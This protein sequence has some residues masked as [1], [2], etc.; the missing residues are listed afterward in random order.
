VLQQHR[1]AILQST[2]QWALRDPQGINA[3]YSI[4]FALMD[5]DSLSRFDHT[6]AAALFAPLAQQIRSVP[7]DQA[8]FHVGDNVLPM[9]F[10]GNWRQF[11][12]R[13]ASEDDAFKLCQ[14]AVQAVDWEREQFAESELVQKYPCHHQCLYSLIKAEI[15][16]AFG[17]TANV[18]Q[19]IAQAIAFLQSAAPRP[20]DNDF[21][22]WLTFTRRINDFSPPQAMRFLQTG[23]DWLHAHEDPAPDALALTQRTIEVAQLRAQICDQQGQYEAAVGWMAQGWFCTDE[24]LGS[25]SQ[26]HSARYLDCLTQLG[27]IEQAAPVALHGV[28]HENDQHWLVAATQLA[29]QHVDSDPDPARRVTRACMLAWLQIGDKA[30]HLWPTRLPDPIRAQLPPIADCLQRARSAARQFADPNAHHPLIALVTGMQHAHQQQWREAL[31]LLEHAVTA[32]PEHASPDIVSRLVMAR[33]C[34]LPLEEALAR[35]FPESHQA[36]W[37]Y[38]LLRALDE[39]L[40]ATV[41]ATLDAAHQQRLPPLDT[42]QARL[43]PLAH[44]YGEAGL[45]RFEA[46]FTSGQGNYYDAY[47]YHYACLCS[48]LAASYR[49]HGGDIDRAIMLIHKSQAARPWPERHR[50]L[51]DC[52]LARAQRNGAPSRADHAAFLAAIDAYWPSDDPRNAYR[53][54]QTQPYFVQVARALGALGR[55]DEIAIW[56]ARLDD[57]FA[58]FQKEGLHKYA[59]R[60]RTD[61]RKALLALLYEL[62]KAQP[63]QALWRLLGQMGNIARTTSKTRIAPRWG[64]VFKTPSGS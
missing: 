48:E 10:W 55:H 2:Y 43:R 50:E 1:D 20:H 64:C 32:L 44:R 45:A 34:T 37:C 27:R 25:R 12:L 47:A 38:R 9:D 23:L 26:S 42:L 56:L 14:L 60:I 35:P 57:W 53:R 52:V 29:L 15:Y 46:F 8:H 17:N 7:H 31:P 41:N 5:A 24:G 3:H 49:V 6:A 58:P 4:I 62:S 54:N 63:W 19:H 30:A 21:S 40:E 36:D 61:F 39:T 51:A 28:L 22:T 11:L 16:Q 13:L 59:P 33:L 18:D